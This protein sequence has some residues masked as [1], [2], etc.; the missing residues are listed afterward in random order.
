MFEICGCSGLLRIY[1]ERRD[2]VISMIA[3][4]QL[5]VAG[6][7]YQRKYPTLH[8]LRLALAPT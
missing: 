8:S 7:L 4:T 6:S 5:V 3:A 2:G 1:C